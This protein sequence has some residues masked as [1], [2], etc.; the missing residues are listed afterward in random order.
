MELCVHSVTFHRADYSRSY[1][2]AKPAKAIPGE[3]IESGLKQ[4]RPD[5]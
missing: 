3:I 1:C 4:N 2:N 5:P